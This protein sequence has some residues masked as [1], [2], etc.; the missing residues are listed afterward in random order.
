MNDEQRFTPAERPVKR[1]N[2]NRTSVVV[3]ACCPLCGALMQVQDVY[4]LCES[5]GCSCCGDQQTKV[6]GS[7][8]KCGKELELTF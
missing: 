7:C 6:L 5:S 4:T 2:R 1:Q 3:T 8:G